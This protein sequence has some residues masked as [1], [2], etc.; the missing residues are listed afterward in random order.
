MNIFRLDPDPVA[1][2]RM[3][4]DI[5]TGSKNRGGK[6]IVEAT[7]MLAN[8]YTLDQLNYAPKTKKGEVRKYSYYNHP[9]SKWTRASLDNFHWLLRHGIAMVEEKLYRGGKLHFCKI[10]S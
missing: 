3:L 5:H 9:C 7:Q 6:M 4:A 1:S 2:A 10:L 8:C